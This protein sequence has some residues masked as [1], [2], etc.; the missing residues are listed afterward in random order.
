MSEILIVCLA[1]LIVM[2]V[3]IA[4]SIGF[5]TFIAIFTAGKVPL[6][7]V[8]QRMFTGVDSF[9]LLAIPLFMLAGS[10]MDRGGI[11]RRLIDLATAFVGHIHGGLGIIAVIACMFFAAISGSAP[12]TVVAIGSIMVPAMIKAGYDKAFSVALLAAAGTIGVVIPPSIPFVTYGVSM[13]ASIGKL[14]AAG[15][16]P[17]ILMGLTLIILCYVVSLR[18]GYKATMENAKGRFAA[19]KEAFWG[20]LMPIIILGGIYGGIFT[21]TEA[22]AVACLY[23]LI[24]G[25]FIYSELS[26]KVIYE[27]LH[28]AAVPSAMVLLIIGCATAMGWITTAE[29]VPHA[30]AAYM[31]TITDSKIA[32]LLMLNGILIIVGCLME[33][34]AAIILLGPI[35]LPLLLQYKIDVVHFGVIMVVNLAVGL[36]TPPLG[37]NLFVANGL[38]KDV[39]FKDIV[40]RV[41]PMVG[42]LFA[43]VL[44][45]S[46]IPVISLFLTRFV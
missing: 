33:L 19:V 26:L 44:I 46:Y 15:L 27:C 10:L 45:L 23:G 42:A 32:M 24:V 13:N 25:L 3:P 9:P 29:K 1:I 8:S 16:V 34:N 12:A 2:N 43:L 11:S 38:R 30:V 35:L 14:F 37:I 6:F 5:A 21:P 39:D 18:R 4:M 40:K 28:T 36:L 31:T 20:L 22:A 41:L 17:G 7:L